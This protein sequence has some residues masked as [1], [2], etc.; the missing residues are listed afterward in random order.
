MLF[1]ACRLKTAILGLHYEP[2]FIA[3]GGF[4]KRLH[5]FDPRDPDSLM[6]KS[7]HAQPILSIAA[8]DKYVITGSEDKTIAIYDRAA[9]KK[10]KQIEIDSFVMAMSYGDGQLWTGDKQGNL[11]VLNAKDGLFDENN[12]QVWIC[13]IVQ[14]YFLLVIFTHC[15]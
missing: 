11:H 5:M 7:Y 3:A 13:C 6:R 12:I 4:D 14:C 15:K 9:G 2:N 8:D 10:Y 1:C